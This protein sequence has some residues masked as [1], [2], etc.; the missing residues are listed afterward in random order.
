M[1]LKDALDKKRTKI[2][3]N[4]YLHTGSHVL[5]D[6]LANKLNDKSHFGYYLKMTYTYDHAV[7]R[8]ILGLVLENKNAKT[9]GRLFA[10]LL[11]QETRN[12][13]SKNSQTTE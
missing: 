2:K 11:K 1:S 10:Y 12:N 8:R 6:E 7:I 9:P 4:P 5:A 3:K 13:D